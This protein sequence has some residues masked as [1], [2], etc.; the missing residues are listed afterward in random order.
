VSSRSDSKIE[1]EAEVEAA[2]E[3]D[4]PYRPVRVHVHPGYS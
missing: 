2:E 1:A 4:R 3:A